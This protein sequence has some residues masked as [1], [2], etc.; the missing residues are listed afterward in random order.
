LVAL[1]EKRL[2]EKLVNRLMVAVDTISRFKVRRTCTQVRSPHVLID[3]RA[4]HKNMRVK[5][6]AG[7]VVRLGGPVRWLLVNI[8]MMK[9]GRGLADFQPWMAG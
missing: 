7:R 8:I 3:R 1:A 6:L 9:I 2:G 5:R 4:I